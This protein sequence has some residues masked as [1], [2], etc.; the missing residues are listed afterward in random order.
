MAG[1]KIESVLDLAKFKVG[2][3]PF[4]VVLRHIREPEPSPDASHRWMFR[5]NVH[6]KVRFRWSDWMRRVW[7]YKMTPPK[8]HAHDF[9]GIVKLVVCTLAIE[10]FEITAVT[11]CQNTGD[12]LYMNETGI[13]WLPEDVCPP[14]WSRPNRNDDASSYYSRP[15]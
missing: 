12:F 8:L 11:R 9:E 14:M 1:R 7:P 15:G 3:K 6:P 10:E 4:W 5:N 2:D 13:E